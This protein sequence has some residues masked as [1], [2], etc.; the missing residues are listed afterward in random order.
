MPVPVSV[1]VSVVVP[2]LDDAVRLAGCL[3]ALH[4]QVGAPAFEVVVVDNGSADSSVAV[5]RAHPLSAVVVEPGF[6][7]DAG[8]EG[9]T[10]GVPFFARGLP[11]LSL[12]RRGRCGQ[13]A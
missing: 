2:V 8:T 10:V 12:T 1:A 9:R 7:A 13:A 4:A 6:T 5:A 11:G 3:D